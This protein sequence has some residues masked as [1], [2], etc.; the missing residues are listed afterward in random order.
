[1]YDCSFMH[2]VAIFC[3]PFKMVYVRLLGTVFVTPKTLLDGWHAVGLGQRVRPGSVGGSEEEE[4]H[5]LP[6]MSSLSG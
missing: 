2:V 6:S 5:G 3:R 4:M 1:M